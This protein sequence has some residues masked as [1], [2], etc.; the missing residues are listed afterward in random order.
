M[1][2]FHGRRRV[3][4]LLA[5]LLPGFLLAEDVVTVAVA[6]N[7]AKAAAEISAAFTQQSKVSVRL[8]QGST[9]KLYAQVINGAPFDIFMS[10]DSERPHLLEQAG[11]I[12]TGRR[13]TYAIGRL[14]LWS[15]DEK[16]RNKDCHEVLVKGE[17]DRLALANP[18]TAPYGAAAREFLE[19][20]GLWESASR[21][22]VF[23]E[24][25]GQTLQFVA[26]G[27]ATLGF[28]ALSQ[29][30]DPNLPPPSCAW[31]V[32]VSSYGS[33]EQQA[34]LLKRA[35]GN[36]DARRFFEFLSSPIAHEIIS[37]QG[38]EVSK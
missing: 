27:N 16:L 7:F 28:V 26:T 6:T 24:N 4:F 23:G 11:H 19:T 30:V 32:P 10:A 2:S 25:I 12:E 18:K 3:V 20:A 33:L 17:Y 34:V 21:R 22:A 36:S 38:Y 35:S 5:V 15:R 31:P 1:F 9:G 13:K 8:S 29:T 14:V 37:Q